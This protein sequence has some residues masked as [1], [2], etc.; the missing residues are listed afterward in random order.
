MR[1]TAFSIALAAEMF[2][3]TGAASAQ[4]P[5][6]TPPTPPSNPGTPGQPVNPSDRT[7]RA[8]R[9]M[10]PAE[11][12]RMRKEWETIKTEWDKLTAEQ[13]TLSVIHA[14]NLEEA[15]MGRLGQSRATS[16]AV[17]DYAAMMVREH[18]DGDAKLTA[19]ASSENITLWDTKRTSRALTLKKMFMKDKDHRDGDKDKNKDKTPGADPN[20]RDADND[21]G[22]P[23][24]TP[25]G[26]P[27]DADRG[28]DHS[29]DHD[30]MKSHE[31]H[32]A[33][34]RSLTGD[35]FDRVYA[36]MM[37]KGHGELLAM[38]EK[39]DDQLTNERV[40]QLVTEV[41]SMVRRHRDEAAKLPGATAEHKPGDNRDENRPGTTPPARDP[42]M[43]DP[44]WDR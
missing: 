37:Y 2:V 21:R 5:A 27:S 31:D 14:K 18:T 23:G 11:R 38:L 34:L 40:K 15:E 43:K 41:T 32:M 17:K 6:Q 24:V 10:D 28:K 25:G 9:P 35:E 19:L 8:E 44:N 16:Q 30:G 26:R 12:E 1:R 22:Q 13:R 20:R 29:K 36:K 4:Q 42:A 3:M 33:K 7:P 39:K